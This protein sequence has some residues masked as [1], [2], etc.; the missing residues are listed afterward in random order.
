MTD[1]EKIPARD[2]A[3]D[4]RHCPCGA[5]TGNPGMR[6]CRKCRARSR[7]RWRQRH[8]LAARRDGRA[9]TGPKGR[10]PQK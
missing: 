2:P 6:L 4:Q 7:Y 3:R 5:L 9:G 1:P 8:G 10:R